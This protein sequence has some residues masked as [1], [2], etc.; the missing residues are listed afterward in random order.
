MTSIRY[1][2]G[3]WPEGGKTFSAAAQYQNL[4]DQN[5]NAIPRP[6]FR[7]ERAELRDTA[8]VAMINP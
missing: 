6:R 5:L 1:P 4:N 7:A 8:A 3:G 2:Q